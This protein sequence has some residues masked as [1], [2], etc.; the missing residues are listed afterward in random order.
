MIRD[1]TRQPD[2]AHAR[3]TRNDFPVRGGL[4]KGELTPPNLRPYSCPLKEV[5]RILHIG[6][7][8]LPLRDMISL[9][10]WRMGL[11]CSGKILP[12]S[13][14]SPTRIWKMGTSRV[15]LRNR[16][17]RS[18]RIDPSRRAIAEGYIYV[19]TKNIKK[20]SNKDQKH[21]KRAWHNKSPIEFSIHPLLIHLKA[22]Y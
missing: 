6:V 8:E 14:P 18:A 17:F 16:S 22:G 7:R 21:V 13:P 1:P 2:R 5:L 9:G 15:S 10:A 12:S 19:K 11:G 20:E 3:T 4:P